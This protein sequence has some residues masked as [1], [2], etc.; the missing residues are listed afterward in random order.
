MKNR[1][2]LSDRKGKDS[3]VKDSTKDS[4]NKET[5]EAVP[6]FLLGAAACTSTGRGSGAYLRVPHSMQIVSLKI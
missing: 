3:Q 2:V 1:S 4:T 5:R 6:E